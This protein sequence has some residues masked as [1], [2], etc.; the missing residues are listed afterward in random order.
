[1]A[2]NTE[3]YEIFYAQKKRSLNVRCFTFLFFWLQIH[4]FKK[5][6]KKKTQ[7]EQIEMD[8]IYDHIE[9]YSNRIMIVVH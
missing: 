2:Q 3:K 4:S 1:M 9:R 7:I 8:M 6:K 5:K